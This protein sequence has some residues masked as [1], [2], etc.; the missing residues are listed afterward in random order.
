[1]RLFVYLL[2]CSLLLTGT[3]SSSV[4]DKILGV[5][6]FTDKSG[7]TKFYKYKGKFY[8]KMI[9]G[10]DVVKSDKKTSKKDTKNPNPKLRNRDILGITFIKGLVYKDNE[11]TD[12]Y[13]YDP[14][15]GK[16]YNCKMWF[17][18]KKLMFRGYKGFSLLGK[19][20]EYRK[21]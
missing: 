12:G 17:E 9:W 20:V 1:M 16:T 5:W 21:L 18:G 15:T 10:K 13:V 14:R 2:F 8:G 3:Q 19:T 7:K 6:E 4:E 11:Y